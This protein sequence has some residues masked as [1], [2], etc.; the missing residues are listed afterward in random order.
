MFPSHHTSATTETRRLRGT[1]LCCYTCM[2]ITPVALQ[3][4]CAISSSHAPRSIPLCHVSIP[5]TT[6]TEHRTQQERHG[7]LLGRESAT[8]PPQTG[9]QRGHGGSTGDTPC[10]SNTPCVQYNA[11]TNS[12]QNGAHSRKPFIATSG[13][14]Y[15][16]R[17]RTN[18]RRLAP[19]SCPTG[20]LVRCNTPA[21]AP[22]ARSQIRPG[23][24]GVVR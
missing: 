16:L 3:A 4:A 17:C 10:Y 9:Q 19:E 2:S 8:A 5:C 6:P 12:R 18:S 14:D 11:N 15:I 23:Q 22:V 20:R 1:L 13:G 21:A 24:D 7:I